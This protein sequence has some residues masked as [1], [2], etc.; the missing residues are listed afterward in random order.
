MPSISSLQ[1]W[2]SKIDINVGILN[3][4]IRM[5]GIFGQN[6]S[7]MDKL[8]VLQFDEMKIR[9]EFEYDKKNDSV[10]GPY[11]QMQVILARGLT[12]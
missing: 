5:I 4:A 10:I 1:K 11:D 2:I 7:E 9:K 6:L 12:S 8:V 3:D